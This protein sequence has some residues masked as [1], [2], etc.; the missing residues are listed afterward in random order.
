[1]ILTKTLRIR[2]SK[3]T[4]EIIWN[5]HHVA[6]WA[7]NRGVYIA[8]NDTGL[9]SFDAYNILTKLRY[10]HEWP[11]K[12]ALRFLRANFNNGYKTVRLAAKTRREREL[13]QLKSPDRLFRCKHT[14]RQPAISSFQPLKIINGTL[15]IGPCKLQLKDTFDSEIKSF[16]IVE[17]TEKITKK[18]QPCDRTYELHVQYE[19]DTPVSSDGDTVALDLNAK[20]SYGYKNTDNGRAGIRKLSRKE[21]RRKYDRDSKMQSH[22]SKVKKGGRTYKNL[23]RQRQAK[24]T[25]ITNRKADRIRKWLSVDLKDAR[26]V[27]LEGLNIDKMTEKGKGKTGLNREMYYSSIGFVREEIIHYCNKHGIH[28]VIIPQEYTSI[29]CAICEHVDEESRYKRGFECTKCNHKNHADLNAPENHFHRA[30]SG[31]VGNI[32]CKQKDAMGRLALKVKSF[33]KETINPERFQFGTRCHAGY[34]CGVLKRYLPYIVPRLL[35]KH[36]DCIKNRCV[37]LC[38]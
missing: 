27:V 7:F 3:D 30:V 18:T 12:Y 17:T 11:L 4:A 15:N 8:F 10:E 25:K 5:L 19:Y 13:S 2:Q 24:N 28:V 29:T 32:V 34:Y 14:D 21:K 31:A 33:Q 37:Y 9:S 38:I 26:V 22:M 20:N 35:E 36:K 6:R 16:Q 1:M 23:Q